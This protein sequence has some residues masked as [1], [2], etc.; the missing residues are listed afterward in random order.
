MVI[1]NK[2]LNVLIFLL[3]IT[4]CIAS[5][6][7]NERRQELRLRADHLQRVLI[8]TAEKAPGDEEHQTGLDTSYVN[9][10]KLNWQAFSAARTVDQTDGTVSFEAY[11][12]EINK[13]GTPETNF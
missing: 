8:S 2:I 4:A 12:N 11:E 6:L 13:F 7:L 9:K 1:V 5:F 10:D 3:A